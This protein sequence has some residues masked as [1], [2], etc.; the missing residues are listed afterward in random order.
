MKKIILSLAITVALTSFHYPFKIEA[1]KAFMIK[2]T[3]GNLGEVDAAKLALQQSTSDSV[4]AFAQMMID[5]HTSAQ[6]ELAAIAK[7]ENVPLPDSTDDAHR[8][9]KQRLM[10]V[11][12]K[13]F[14]SAYMQ[15]Q[16]QDH[17]KTIAM[18]QAEAKNG[19]DAQTKAY[20]NKLLPK[21]Q[22]HLQHAQSVAQSS[23]SGGNTQ[24]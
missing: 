24:Q 13:T 2:A 18:F 20:A 14:D 9:F 7:N 15:A 8:M 6:T 22:M 17:V 23:M 11:S 4:K 3:Q 19:L 12:G 16:V 21:L 1:D 5:D 10:Q